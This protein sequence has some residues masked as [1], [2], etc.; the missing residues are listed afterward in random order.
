M[1]TSRSFEERFFSGKELYGDDFNEQEIAQWFSDEQHGYAELYGSD[2]TR[3]E[4]GYE[5]LNNHQGFS[6]IPQSRK[7]RH[8]L[9]F[10]SNFGDELVPILDRVEKITLLDSSDR[11]VVKDIRGVPVNY[12]LA[13]VS[14]NIALDSRSIDLITC[15]GVLHHIP[16]V[17]KV[18]EEFGRV[19]AP[20][21]MLLVR[22][23]AHTMGDWR[24][25]RPGLTARERGIPTDV[26]FGML[27]SSGLAVRNT[28]YWDFRPWIQ[29]TQRF[30][31][32][33]FNH[34]FCTA[35]DGI[36]APAFKWNSRYHRNSFLEKFAPG[37]VFC[38]AE[39]I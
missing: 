24:K 19:L 32:N 21:G 7:F 11:Y 38:I 31:I 8:A 25:K 34:K 37:S 29:L 13:C 4:Y 6:R 12:I 20:G 28:S 22:E 23:P 35:V 17:S 2:Q 18:I 16:N 36:L 9:G 27:E 15:F 30:G 33:P 39:K 10:G 26:L 5:A 14:G 1:E 3:H